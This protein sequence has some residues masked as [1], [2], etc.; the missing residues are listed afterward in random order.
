MRNLICW[1]IF[2][3]IGFLLPLLLLVNHRSHQPPHRFLIPIPAAP[4]IVVVVADVAI[5]GHVSEASRR[6]HVEGEVEGVHVLAER[7]TQQRVQTTALGP[8]E[9]P[10]LD[11][12][13][14][15]CPDKEA[16][17]VADEGEEEDQV[18][19]ELAVDEE[20]VDY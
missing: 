2:F 11:G 16:L 10:L 5:F 3:F 19:D 13:H 8:R 6:H 20:H 9:T 14:V 18:D 15:V 17:H 4:D 12:G 1:L 7:A